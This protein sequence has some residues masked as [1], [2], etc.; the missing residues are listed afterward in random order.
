MQ[1]E[2]KLDKSKFYQLRYEKENKNKTLVLFK[3]FDQKTPNSLARS[4]FFRDNYLPIVKMY[5]RVDYEYSN[6][7]INNNECI[8]YYY[9]NK[10]SIPPKIEIDGII[11]V[12]RKGLDPEFEATEYKNAYSM[13][14][15]KYL[16]SLS[17]KECVDKCKILEEF[18]KNPEAF[19][20]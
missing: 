9:F 7:E 13:D 18:L 15:R 5:T 12:Y 2:L 3:I 10:Y 8:L 6:G 17:Y 14:N 20:K 16:R 1:I 11:F 4:L 19:K